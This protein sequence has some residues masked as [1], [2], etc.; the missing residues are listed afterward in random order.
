MPTGSPTLTPTEPT[1]EQLKAEL[2]RLRSQWDS[3]KQALDKANQLLAEEETVRQAETREQIFYRNAN[4]KLAMQLKN[5][6]VAM[7]TLQQP[8]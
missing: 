2:E 3:S 5:Y 1:N 8:N 4:E 6:K 7:G